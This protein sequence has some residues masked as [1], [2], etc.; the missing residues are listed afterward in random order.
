MPAAPHTGK[1][2]QKPFLLCVR[3]EGSQESGQGH[4]RAGGAATGSQGA[5]AQEETTTPE[6][7]GGPGRGAGAGMKL[8]VP[9]LYGASDGLAAGSQLQVGP[10]QT[11][12]LPQPWHPA[13]RRIRYGNEHTRALSPEP[14]GGAGGPQ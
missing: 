3:S 1:L 14:A 12:A 5:A 7:G 13:S 6:A 9:L 10:G 2:P 4:R 8:A 11:P